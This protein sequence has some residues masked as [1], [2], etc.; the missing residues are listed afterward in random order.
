MYV[1]PSTPP[2][3]VE[4]FALSSTSIY[5]LWDAPLPHHQNGLI[6]SYFVNVTEDETRNKFGVTVQNTSITLE[7]LHPSYHYRCTVTAVTVFS[8]PPSSGIVIKTEED[9]T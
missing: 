3:N 4:G 1:A 6:R 5:L 2:L 8:G 7:S 9:G